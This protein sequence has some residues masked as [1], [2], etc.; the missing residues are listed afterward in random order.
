MQRLHQIVLTSDQRRELTDL[1]RKGVHPAHQ[2][3]H[4]RIL[5]AA[6][7][8][9]RRARR[10]DAE[11]AAHCEVSARTVARVRQRFAVEGFVIARD[12]RPRSGRSQRLDAAQEAQVTALACST[13]P[14]GYARWSLRLLARE[15]QLVGLPPMSPFLVRATLKKSPSVPSNR[16]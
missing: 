14:P 1:L 16:G 6:D 15:V 11:V 10:T 9:V 7:D 2:V 8:G 13:P 4:A 3:R 5:L 12:G